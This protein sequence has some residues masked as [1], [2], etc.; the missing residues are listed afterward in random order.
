VLSFKV[1]L[2][3]RY[4]HALGVHSLMFR[5]TI[6]RKN[7]AMLRPIRRSLSAMTIGERGATVGDSSSLLLFSQ[8]LQAAQVALN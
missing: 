1:K 3:A 8:E 5:E 4:K 7:S 2:A 6:L